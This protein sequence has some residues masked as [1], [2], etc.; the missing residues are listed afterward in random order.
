[1]DDSTRAALEA[2]A[3]NWR[4]EHAVETRVLLYCDRLDGEGRLAPDGAFADFIALAQACGLGVTGRLRLLLHPE[5]GPWIAIRAILLSDWPASIRDSDP[6]VSPCID[7]A[8]PCVEACPGHALDAG[9][10]DFGLCAE[11]RLAREDCGQGCAAR[12]SCV[13]GREHVY[14]AKWEARYTRS[15]MA[16]LRRRRNPD[17]S[18]RG[19][20]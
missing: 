19:P 17:E 9:D 2:V 10:L 5:Y 4:E 12:R 14:P 11:T 7:C 20:S 1:V 8:A 15:V 13:L 18:P 16:G 3:A 6:V